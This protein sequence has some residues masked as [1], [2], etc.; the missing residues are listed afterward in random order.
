I[1]ELK[2]FFSNKY[3]L[4][5]GDQVSTKLI[6]NLLKKLID[7]EIKD[8]PL[9]D[10]ALANQLKLKGYPLARRTVAKYREELKLPAARLRRQIIN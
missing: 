5:S 10:T 8:E 3:N 6:K 1:F 4:A 7:D 9:T 2:S